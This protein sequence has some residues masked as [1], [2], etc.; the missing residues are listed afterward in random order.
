M[1]VR[2]HGLYWQRDEVDWSRIALRARSGCW[3]D[4]ATTTQSCTSPTSGIRGIYV[5]YDDYGPTDVGLARDRGI[6][7][8]LRRHTRDTHRDSWDRFSW[9]GA[10]NV[11]RPQGPDRISPL[12]KIPKAFLD[13]SDRTIA[14]LE[15]LLILTLGTGG[16]GN[17]QVMR[18]S[19][20]TRFEQVRRDETDRY[21][22]LVRGG[23]PEHH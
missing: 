8:R 21:L 16:R 14:D 11:L 4:S 3:A 7:G 1:F 9:F 10:R 15:A 6:G 17:S 19:R 23:A 13:R 22:R 20:A 18:F 2:A 5:L 12:G